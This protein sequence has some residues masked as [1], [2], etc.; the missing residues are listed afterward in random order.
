MPQSQPAAAEIPAELLGVITVLYNS[1]SVLEGFFA[2]LSLQREVRL[3]LYVIDNSPQPAGL[4]M[5]RALAAKHGID[6]VFVANHANLGIAKGNNQ[7]IELALTDGC[8]FVLLANNDIEFPAGTISRLLRSCVQNGSL[9]ASPKIH[10]H[11]TDGR[12]WYAGGRI[13][14]TL[15][16]VHHFGMRQA[17]HGQFDGLRQ[18]G[19]APACFL[20]LRRDIFSLVGIM[21]EQ[22]FVYYDDADFLW[23]MMQRG[24]AVT[25]DSSCVVDHKVSTLTGGAKSAFSLYYL[26]RNRIYF[27]RKHR[28]GIAKALTLAFALCTRI[29]RT[30]MLPRAGF[31]N[32]WRGVR[33]GFR[34]PIVP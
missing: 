19:Y 22:Y 2:S 8:G 20:L 24:L 3:R 10:F 31:A 6:S 30:L 7:G 33:D 28:R 9:A 5:A 12:L 1:E 16:L 13:S 21:D 27:I 29:P 32:V 25:F 18:V 17:D 23:R 34:L 15:L 26:N 11:G 14:R 4:D